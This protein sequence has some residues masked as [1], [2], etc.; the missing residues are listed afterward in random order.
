MPSERKGACLCALCNSW[1]NSLIP[2]IKSAASLVFVNIRDATGKNPFLLAWRFVSK[3]TGVPPIVLWICSRFA[4]AAIYNSVFKGM[5]RYRLKGIFV[6]LELQAKFLSFAQE[7]ACMRGRTPAK[8]F[9][10]RDKKRLERCNDMND[11]NFFFFSSFI[12]L[13]RSH[14][15]AL[16]RPSWTLQVSWHVGDCHY[17]TIF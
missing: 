1:L 4:G 5:P 16:L 15:C 12:S 2:F 3:R 11:R 6:Y 7:L 13:Y 8:S 14:H 17:F 9:E 10:A